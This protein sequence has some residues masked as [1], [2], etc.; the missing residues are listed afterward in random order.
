[1][2]IL[3][4]SATVGAGH[5]VIAQ[6]ISNE[7]NKMGNETKIVKIF[8]KAPFFNWIL[9]NVFF[10]LNA[11]TPKIFSKAYQQQKNKKQIP[12]ESLILRSAKKYVLKEINEFKPDA[13]F[14]TIVYAALFLKKYKNLIKGN[15]QTYFY[16]TDYDL[17]PQYKKTSSLDYLV[18]P[19]EDLFN[20]VIKDGFSAERVYTV[21]LPVAERF[22]LQLNKN[23]LL[24]KYNLDPNIFTILIMSGAAGGADLK[25]ILKSLSQE[26]EKLQLIIVNGK[27]KK[28]FKMIEKLKT[29]TNKTVLNFGYCSNIDELMEISNLLIGKPGG[30]TLN[31]SMSKQL[32]MC[33]LT[34]IPEPELSNLKFF[35]TKGMMIPIDN[36]KA[37][38]QTIKKYD[39][40]KIKSAIK[41]HYN[42]NSAKEISFIIH[43]NLKNQTSH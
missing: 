22:N 34:N 13:I 19:T 18:I 4:L 24:K 30:M 29:K 12:F 37:I 41:N 17:M 36:N 11:L 10:K 28:T 35:E 14:C 43:N 33:S 2:K 5:N 39:L 26:E 31:E 1:M 6:N 16:V 25:Q 15:P 21:N 38:L 20:E 8:E 40:N 32:P 9:T 7:L 27:N 3:F 23:E 42:P